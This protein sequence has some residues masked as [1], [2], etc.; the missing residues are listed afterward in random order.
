MTVYAWALGRR[1]QQTDPE[2]AACETNKEE[3][4]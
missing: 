3:A 2:R 1:S 4:I